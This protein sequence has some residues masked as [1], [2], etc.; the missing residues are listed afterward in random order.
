MFVVDLR[1]MISAIKHEN[2]MILFAFLTALNEVWCASGYENIKRSTIYNPMWLL[3][4]RMK[5]THP[6]NKTYRI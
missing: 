6:R 5:V 4:C 3:A 1:M 2:S